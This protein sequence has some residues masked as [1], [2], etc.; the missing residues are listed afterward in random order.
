MP[1][2]LPEWKQSPEPAGRRGFIYLLLICQVFA[3]LITST[4]ATPQ[5][6][7]PVIASQLF[8]EQELNWLHKQTWLDA[9]V[10]D[11]WPPISQADPN[12]RAVGIDPEIV[13]E[14]NQRLGGKIRLHVA[15]W[16]S[17]YEGMRQGRLDLIMGITPRDF[18][19]PYMDFTTPYLQVPHVIVA[20]NDETRFFASETD[21]DGKTLALEKDF[22]NVDYFRNNF[23]NVSI[24]TWPNT[25]DALEAVSRGD[26]DAYAGSRVVVLHLI[27]SQLLSNLRIHGRLAKPP[28][29]LAIGSRKDAPLLAAILQKALSDIPAEDL[30][31]IIS[32]WIPLNEPH[33][34][35]LRLQLSP[36]ERQWL[37]QHPG[38]SV[39]MMAS[40]PPFSFVDNAGLVSGIS[41]DILHE[42]EK[43]LGYRFNVISGDWKTIYSQT[44]NKQLDLL[45]DI[46]PKPEREGSFNFS[47]AYLD[48]P[49]VIIA[50]RS[51][52]IYRSEHDLKDKTLALEEGFG[53][54][55]YFRDNFP[56]IGLKLYGNTELAL[57]AVVRGDADAYAGN[58]V[59]ALHLIDRLALSNLQVH[60]RL[61]KSGSVLSIGVRK[62]FMILRDIL[63]KS[64]DL[65]GEQKLKQIKNNWIH[66]A[67]DEPWRRL[68]L[69][70]AERA[71]LANHREIPIGVDGHWP[72]IDF[73]DEQ[74]HHA[75][76]T[77]D[78][79]SAIEQMLEVEFLP[80]SKDSFK[81]M[82]TDVMNGELKVG[83]SISFN[84]ERARRLLFSKPFF[85][86]QKVIMVNTDRDIGVRNI[87]QLKNRRVAV[88]DGFLTMQQLQEKYPSI[89]LVAV[90]STLEALQKLSWGEV[91]A[92]IGN[93]AVASWLS[94]QHQLSNLRIVSDA[95]L[96]SGPQNFA[97]TRADP[98]WAPLVGILDKA[99]EGIKV[100]QQLEIEKKWL[101][102]L[103]TMAEDVPSLE[104][105]N[106][107]KQWL[108]QHPV[109]RLGVDN[110]WPP[111]EYLDEN[112]QYKGLSSD[113]I[114]YFLRQ[115]GIVPQAPRK[116]PWSRV[117]DELKKGNIEV[118][119]MLIRTPQREQFLNFTKP[120]ISFPVV[121]F[122]QRGQTL[123]G[124]MTDLIGQRV[125]IVDG[126]AIGEFMQRDFPGIRQVRFKGSLEGLQALSTGGIDAFIDVLSV[127]AY[128]TA[129]HGMSNVQ[130]AASTP[131]RHDFSVGV[132]KDWPQLVNILNKAIDKMPIEKKNAFLR[133]WLA[134]KF[135]KQID[136]SLMWWVIG[137]ATLIIGLIT[138]R[139]RVMSR[140]NG[141]LQEWRER[142]TLTL[143]SAELG[144]FELYF[145]RPG[146]PSFEW[147]ETFARH[148]R[149]PAQDTGFDEN[150][151]FFSFIDAD[152][153][154]RVRL[155]LIAYLKGEAASFN[156]EYQTRNELEWIN[157]QGRVLQRDSSGWA[158][159]MVGISR[160]ITQQKEAE[161]AILRSSHFKSQFLANMS[162]EIRTPMNAIV[163]LGYLL[164]QTDL[165]DI[166][167]THL[168]K[169]QKSTRILLGLIDDIL[170]FSKIEAGR[171][172]IDNI[173]FDLDTL[174]S[175]LADMARMRLPEHKVEFIY[176]MD[177]AAP[178]FL[179]GDP[180]RV[181]QVLTN[182]I[183]NA[184]KFTD[185]GHIMLK[186]TLEEVEHDVAW[187]QF[188]IIDTGIGIAREKLKGLFE[189]FEQEDGSTT[190][191]YGGTGLG[192]S[193]SKQFAS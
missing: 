97:V 168:A 120:Y 34:V 19:R 154:E 18:R 184:I 1:R 189:P 147:D 49:H 122:N 116:I 187:L 81:A 155:E 54:V 119:P 132:R 118:A 22:V 107:L 86:V 143:E 69:S 163:G 36:A 2:E 38:L 79:L 167:A 140:V 32:R 40:W 39:G 129:F 172:K 56:G 100:E 103:Q 130:V 14:L 151:G 55:D 125:G 111:L 106:E 177:P 25:L 171:L 181:N 145:P 185:Q 31:R 17:I 175:D 61:N 124:G 27:Q 94:H 91:D 51:G 63:Q 150:N 70:D 9:G 160:N 153:A 8:N 141:Q 113:F 102:P 156:V 127:G 43:T 7:S 99:L 84:D 12:A 142:Q 6:T 191:K 37:D 15:P 47:R 92:Y 65:I 26:A 182:L 13:A 133:K 41:K 95:G 93:Q 44:E 73:F 193:I 121:I 30:R 72:P 178:R 137:I 60:G 82:L 77:A 126:Y 48:V 68:A 58:R 11:D 188:Q 136:Y 112:N 45:F 166:Q 110:A 179:V 139:G 24:T 114:H 46:T 186:V 134:I 98:E 146:P 88:E 135:E 85:H 158:E 87:E 144:T 165:T 101:T 162:H 75:G 104:L 74:Q 80:R 4:S 89:E 52:T 64:L 33:E 192:L 149:L 59:V 20:R 57:E 183:S 161:H 35:S 131:Y 115:I 138:Y 123:L 109:I 66:L 96:G 152:H 180:F 117:I 108:T 105:D 157:V 190:R 169:L 53:N 71:W 23:P 170:D 28:T 16:D 29:E 78:Y 5:S 173:E 67:D 164:S 176:D 50:P 128:L 42:I 90:D 76:I 148:H 3:S 10:M 174:L 21:L 83:A 159:R 62:D